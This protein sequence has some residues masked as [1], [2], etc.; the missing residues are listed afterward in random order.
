M[1]REYDFSHAERGAIS[2]DTGKAQITLMLDVAVIDAARKLAD[3]KG[4]GCQ[5]LI[6]DVLSKAL[7]IDSLAII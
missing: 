4:V 2:T 6:N 5:S 3:E 1:K 7:L